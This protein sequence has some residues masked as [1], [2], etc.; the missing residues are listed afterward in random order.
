M[1]AGL[2]GF[3]TLNR[4][5]RNG[6]TGGAGG[7]VVVVSTFAALRD[8]IADNNPRIVQ[9]SGTIAAEG[10]V[11]MLNVGSNKS[12]HGIGSTAQLTGFGLDVSGWTLAVRAANGGTECTPDKAA[13]FTHVQ[14]VIIRNITFNAP[15]DDG[16]QVSCYSHHVWLDHN[17]FTKGYDGSI[18]IKRGSDWVTVSWNHFNHTDKTMLLGHD[19]N[20]GPQDIGHLHV[21]YHHNFLDYSTQ[22]NP[23]VRFGQAHVYNNYGNQIS[24]Y[25]IGLGV[26]CDVYA[27]G[28]YLQFAD[29]VTN[30]FGGD[31]FTW[32]TSNIVV[33]TDLAAVSRNNAFNPASYYSYTPD[34]AA[35]LP[36]IVS[37]GAGVGKI[38]P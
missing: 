34:A 7:P 12:I 20:N 26:G 30:D 17:S 37:Q 18:D 8:A 21:T 38:V 31:K 25:M 10:G 13:L 22:R 35:N 28:N 36:T 29:N 24:S 19:D 2:V 15:T 1:A 6:T 11:K 14:N 4:D 9:I 5:G 23:R 3:A 32:T 27:D 16:I 33:A